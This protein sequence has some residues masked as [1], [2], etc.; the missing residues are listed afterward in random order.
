MTDVGVIPEDWEVKSIGDICV[1]KDGT[2]QTPNYTYF[3]I[4]FYSVENISNNDFSNV[5]YI[6]EEE[7][8]IL[9]SNSKIEK[10]D[11]F[12]TRTSETP[13]EVGIASVLLDDLPKGVFSGFLLRAR[14]NGSLFPL[15][16]LPRSGSIFLTSQSSGITPTSVILYPFFISIPPS[17]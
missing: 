14:P 15:L 13:E 3:G 11:V 6:S 16:T 8:I 4:P 17:S 12:F 10:G 7:H 9:S 2:H 1:V 5:K